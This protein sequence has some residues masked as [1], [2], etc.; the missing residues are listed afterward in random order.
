MSIYYAQLLKRSIPVGPEDPAAMSMIVH[1]EMGKNLWRFFALLYT[2]A[3]LSGSMVVFLIAAFIWRRSVVNRVSLRL[4]F[5]MSLCD[6]I[7]SMVSYKNMHLKNAVECRTGGFFVDYTTASSIYLSS[8][9]AFNLHMVFLRKSRKPLPK[10]TEILY[11]V[12]PLTV[13]LFQFAPQYIWTAKNGF[14]YTF[15]P[16]PAGTKSYILHVIF[17]YEL[18]PGIFV[19]YNLITSTRVIITLYM[20]QR[21]VSRALHEASHET[22]LLL[23]G[24][25]GES[26]E[27]DGNVSSG[28]KRRGSLSSKD[29][30]QLKAVRKVYRACMR[31]ALYPIVPLWWWVSQA[32]FYWCQYPLN[33]TFRWHASLMLKLM[34]ISW[35]TF[36][37]VIILNFAVFVTDPSILNVMKEVRKSILQRLGR[38]DRSH[39]F[40]VEGSHDALNTIK[41]KQQGV[42]ITEHTD[43]GTIHTD[44][45]SMDSGDLAKYKIQEGSPEYSPSALEEN[46]SITTAYA[47]FDDD[48]LI[49]RARAP[50][51]IEDIYDNI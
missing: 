16:V 38:L 42:V 8:S 19:F 43:S 25:S 6:F 20:R 1:D 22:R 30:R 13:A 28:G 39:E 11:Y 7:Q 12:V 26:E 44:S 23:N 21:K 37:A 47:S 15:D 36:S 31:I 46:G 50:G 35:T 48:A 40:N 10:Y 27:K 41:H 9:I 14:C 18:I 4:I 17:A 33:M 29:V 45:G 2:S 24:P 5:A 49:R 51:N 3:V 34:Y 32:I